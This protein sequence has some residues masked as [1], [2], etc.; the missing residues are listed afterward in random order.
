MRLIS[1]SLTTPQFLDGSKDVTRRM[2]WRNLK[3]GDH[4][5]AVEK[6]MGLRKGQHPVKLGVIEV[7][8]VRRE[9]LYEMR[10]PDCAREGFPGM[11]AIEFARMFCVH[12][13]LRHD[14]VEVTRIEFRRVAQEAKP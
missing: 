6:A 3:A 12:H 13:G 2:G 9:L 1:F 8:D 11:N 14:Q 5:Q 7:V 4:L 10:D